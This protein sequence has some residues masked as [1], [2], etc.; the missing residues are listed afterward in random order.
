LINLPCSP[1]LN[2][3]PLNCSFPLTAPLNCSYPSTPLNYT[4]QLQF[5]LDYTP[6]LQFPLDYTP[7]LQ[8]P[9][10][11]TPLKSP[12]LHPSTAVSSQLHASN[13]LNCT[14]Q[15]H[16]LQF[17]GDAAESGSCV[18]LLY[19]FKSDLCVRKRTPRKKSP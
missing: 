19:I 1:P 3:N 15:L 12:Q 13:P 5:P 2:R 17:H 14:P 10:N 6:Q 11:C 7:Q 18:V 9:F 16:S 8:F 4:P